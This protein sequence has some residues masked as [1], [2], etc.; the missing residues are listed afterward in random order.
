[1]AYI[2]PSLISKGRGAAE[3]KN[4]EIIIID[5]AELANYQVRDDGGVVMVGAYTMKPGKYITKMAVTAS[6]TS[7]GLASE[8]EED[9]VSINALPEFQFPGSTVDAEEFVGN[10]LNRSII[11]GVRI[12][13]CG[14]PNGFY[15]MYGSC[16]APLSLLPEGTNNNDATAIMMKFQQYAKTGIMP[17]R[18]YGTF[19]EA[20]SNVV[21][22]D[23]TTV[24]VDGLYGEFQL[25]DNAAA[26]EIT[27]IENATTGKVYT[28]IGSGGTNPA[29]IDA[30][31]TNFLL[32]GAVDWQGLVN[33][34][35]T[36]EA[37]DQGSGD[38][39]F[40][41]KSRS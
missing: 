1:M 34:R 30:T 36:F 26:T 16:A 10:W 5:A 19:T 38:H 41:E 3:S 7:L 23:A 20:T 4:Q 32:V 37:H 25:Q 12:G 17:G 27:D 11:I 22:A 13:S 29:T 28:L 8:G 15:R 18:Y 2:N 14:D 6:K 31:N 9:N 33:S 24:D 40:V 35:I 39:V 21:D